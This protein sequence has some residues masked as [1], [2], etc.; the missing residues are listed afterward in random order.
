M[1]LAP[2][3]S[4]GTWWPSICKRPTVLQGG[5]RWALAG[6]D[7]AK[8]ATVRDAIGARATLHL[9]MADSSDAAALAALAARTCVILTIVGPYQIHGEALGARFAQPGTDYVDLCGEPAWMAK[10]IPRL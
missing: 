7:A 8:L 10:M 3:A 6:R 9:V 5:L 1:F 4:P 2:P